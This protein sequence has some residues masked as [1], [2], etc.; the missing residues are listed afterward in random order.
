[1]SLPVDFRV[2]ESLTMKDPAIGYNYEEVEIRQ[3][4]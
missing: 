3:I 4:L 1:M 2:S